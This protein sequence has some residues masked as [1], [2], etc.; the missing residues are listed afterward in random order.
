MASKF[1]KQELN[2]NEQLNRVSF[3]IGENMTYKV[4]LSKDNTLN[5]KTNWIELDS[6]TS[7][8]YGIKSKDLQDIEIDNDFSIILE[9]QIPS[10]KISSVFTTCDYYDDNDYITFDANKNFISQNGTTW[11]DMNNVSISGL[12][13]KC[14]PNIYVYTKQ[15]PKIDI[16]ETTQE[17][18]TTSVEINTTNIDTENINFVVKNKDGEDITQHFQIVT[19]YE[20]NKIDIISDNTVDGEFTC[21]INYEGI[22]KEISF[23]L[24]ESVTLKDETKM[25]IENNNIYVVI[26]NNESFNYQTFINNLNIE[27]TEVK[28]YDSDNNNVSSNDS[29]LGTG[30]KVETNNQEY[31]IVVVGDASGD[32]TIDSGDLLSVVKHLKNKSRLSEK[33]ELAADCNYD[34]TV[35]SG[36]LLTIVKFLK[37]KGTIDIKN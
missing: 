37:K 30:S 22:E 18:N 7:S 15:S 19:D 36:D 28:T 32:G 35:D 10:S 4:Y 20:N 27:N 26:D 21:I 9:Y 25:K 1:T 23:E 5:D 17:G 13:I 2:N 6:G 14:Q 29:L 34:D 16:G 8:L 33:Q 12:N 3:T 31:N 11:T 24:I